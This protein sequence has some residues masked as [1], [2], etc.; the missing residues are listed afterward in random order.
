MKEKP[1]V[2]QEKT[3]NKNKGRETNVPTCREPATTPKM[4]LEKCR[5]GP[6]KPHRTKTQCFSLRAKGSHPESR[7][8]YDV[9]R[10]AFYKR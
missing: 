10:L 9:S 1:W 4:E 5:A 2:P 8:G 3:K 6:G 7:V